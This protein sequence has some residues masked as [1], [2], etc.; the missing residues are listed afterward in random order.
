MNARNV[1]LIGATIIVLIGIAAYFFVVSPFLAQRSV[2]QANVKEVETR[3]SKVETNIISLE[4]DQ[5]LTP[6]VQLIDQDMS[7]MFPSTADIN[8]LRSQIY[9]IATASSVS[10]NINSVPPVIVQAPVVSTAPT[11][12]ETAEGEEEST[13]GNA[14]EAPPAQET[15]NIA[16]FGV[17]V[18]A[19]GSLV[20]VMNFLD[21]MNSITRGVLITSATINMSTGSANTA[22]ESYRLTFEAT[23]FIHRTTEPPVTAEDGTVTTPTDDTTE[24]AENPADAPSSEG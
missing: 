21:Q 15:A 10:V 17:S 16:Q 11:T 12:D 8:T 20:D 5:R 13:G 2:H 22:P 3:I 23:S 9:A 18:T 14:A 24:D 19:E 7:L 6:D 4:K 1:K